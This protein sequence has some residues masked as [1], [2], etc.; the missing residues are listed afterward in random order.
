MEF[1]LECIGFPP[2]CNREELA[3]QVRR[4]GEPAPWRGPGGEHLRLPLG[5]G[6]GLR[7]ERERQDGPLTLLPEFRSGR[8]LRVAVETLRVPPD[9]P[10]DAVI[11]GWAD[12]PVTP[13]GLPPGRSFYPGAYELAA[14]LID[15]RRLP[16]WLPR[17]HVL[18]LE[19]AGFALDVEYVGP[20]SGGRD[21]IARHLD[22]GAHIQPLVGLDA[23][24]GCIEASFR[25]RAVRELDNPVTGVPVQLVEVD[26]PGRGLQLFVSRWQLEG[27]RLPAPRPGWRIEGTFLLSGRAMGG[28]PSSTGKLKGLFG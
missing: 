4:F 17:G 12:P 11:S 3:S 8:R 21:R 2:G 18:A 15:A 9:S 6:L 23:P 27:D 24:G 10:F 13:P 16:R 28:L 19:L 5:D 20:D 7:V 1:L 22:C 26:A 14:V 25:I